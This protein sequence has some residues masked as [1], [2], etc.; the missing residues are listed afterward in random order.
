MIEY[1]DGGPRPDQSST[2]LFVGGPRDGEREPVETPT[3][4]EIVLPGGAYARSVQC[5]DDGA[6]RYV[7]APRSTDPE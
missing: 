6:L 4:S 7:W 2:I 5:A 3:P 1:L